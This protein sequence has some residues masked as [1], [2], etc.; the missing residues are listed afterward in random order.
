MAPL[1]LP[2]QIKRDATKDYLLKTYKKVLVVLLILEDYRVQVF[3]LLIKHITN[4]SLNT[5][6]IKIL[7]I[8]LDQINDVTYPKDYT[9]FANTYPQICNTTTISLDSNDASNYNRLKTIFTE[10]LVVQA[11]VEAYRE[12]IVKLIK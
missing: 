7:A 6:F 11:Y 10:T 8:H 9:I 5:S 3:D 12:R 4:K 2:Q 1:T